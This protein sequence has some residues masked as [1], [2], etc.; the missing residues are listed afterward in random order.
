[1]VD[2]TTYK[3]HH[4]PICLSY[5]VAV[6]PSKTVTFPEYIAHEH[7]R[8]EEKRTHKSIN[9]TI[10]SLLIGSHAL[11]RR[12]T[13]PLAGTSMLLPSRPQIL[14]G[15]PVLLNHQP[16]QPFVLHLQTPNALLQ[17]AVLVLEVLG[18]LL[19]GLFALLL[20]DAEAR[21]GGRVA[22]AFVFFGREAVGGGLGLGRVGGCCRGRLRRGRGE[23]VFLARV[24]GRVEGMVVG[25]GRCGGGVYSWLE[26]IARVL[27]LDGSGDGGLG[28]R[29]EFHAREGVVAWR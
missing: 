7:I 22:A 4:I 6:R 14:L 13:F 25:D 2:E 19:E 9:Q 21:R 8:E 20:L 11:L 3:T 18:R 10:K 27:G 26:T 5:L 1:M 29:G 24:G 15:A 12:A 23:V 28:R 16:L 17:Q